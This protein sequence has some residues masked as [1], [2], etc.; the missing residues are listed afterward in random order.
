MRKLIILFFL[1]GFSKLGF[2]HA[3]YFSFAEMQYNTFEKR[4]EITLRATGHDVEEYMEHRKT[5]I[6]SLESATNN[7]L[8]KKMLE[9][10]INRGFVIS[11]DQKDLKL[12]LVGMEVDKNDE[13]R[14]YLVSRT[15]DYPKQIAVRYDFLMDYFPEQQNKLTIFDA[16]K[17]EYLS[18]L[19]HL[20][21]RTY[22]FTKP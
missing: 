10:E 8:K 20:A 11:M 1:I 6:G 17:K 16:R 4:F 7:P 18:F 22:E 12:E 19:P 5:P 3:F 14:F 15:I 21:T 9:D 13:V 2:A